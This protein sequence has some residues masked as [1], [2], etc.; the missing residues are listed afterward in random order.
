MRTATDK[1]K[2]KQV[3]AYRNLFT[4]YVNNVE[5]RVIFVKDVRKNAIAMS[6]IRKYALYIYISK[7]LVFS[8]FFFIVMD[9]FSFV[10]FINT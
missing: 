6:Y 1:Y 8:M 3:Y 2:F 7:Y 9:T 5:K 10:S 4:T